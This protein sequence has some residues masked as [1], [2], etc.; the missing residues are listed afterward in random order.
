MKAA[1]DPTCCLHDQ[2]DLAGRHTGK[3]ARTVLTTE[4]AKAGYRSCSVTG[5]SQKLEIGD[6]QSTGEGDAWHP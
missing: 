4:R 5:S 1:V 6:R 3:E 2:L